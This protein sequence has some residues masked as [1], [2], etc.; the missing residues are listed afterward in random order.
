MSPPLNN[1]R[2]DSSYRALSGSAQPAEAV[3]RIWRSRQ[4]V[5]PL[6]LYEHLPSQEAASLTGAILTCQP[7][8]SSKHAQDQ[9]G[10]ELHLGHSSPARQRLPPPPRTVPC[11]QWERFSCGV[12]PCCFWSQQPLLERIHLSVFLVA[13]LGRACSSTCWPWKILSIVFWKLGRLCCE[14][15]GKIV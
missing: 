5:T 2:W 1:P 10:V 6:A 3:D 7:L 12:F 11:V 14:V 13:A 8:G 4:S 15:F 9:P